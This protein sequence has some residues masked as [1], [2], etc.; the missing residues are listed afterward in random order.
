MSDIG[1]KL[2]DIVHAILGPDGELVKQHG[3]KFNEN[4]LSYA[5]AMAAHFQK[6][7]SDTDGK[8]TLGALQAGTGTGKTIGYLVPMLAYVA[9]TGKKG[10]VSTYTRALQSQVLKD[11]SLLL[12]LV[13]ELTGHFAVVRKRLGKQN[14]LSWSGINR[15]EDALEEGAP[16]SIDARRTL[17]RMQSWLS[18]RNEQGELVNS[19]IIAD[20]AEAEDDGQITP[21]I[22]MKLIELR[23]S[24]DPADHEL[25]SRDVSLA[26]DADIVVV[27]H[28]T[29]LVDAISWGCVLNTDLQEHDILVVDE[30]DQ[31]CSAAEMICNSDI[32]LFQAGRVVKAAEMTLGIKGTHESLKSLS[33]EA[34][35]LYSGAPIIAL[36]ANGKTAEA[37]KRLHTSAAAVSDLAER[38]RK[39]SK[40]KGLTDTEKE[41][42]AEVGEVSVLMS[43]A[44]RTIGAVD[45]ALA[46]SW[47][48]IKAYPSIRIGDS[49]PGRVMGKYWA[50]LAGEDGEKSTLLKSIVFTSATLGPPGKRLPEAFDEFLN[51]IGVYRINKSSKIHYSVCEELMAMYEPSQFGKM[52]FVLCDPSVPLPS[53]KED[54]VVT[55]S[56]EWLTY[57]QTMIRKAHETGGRVLVLTVS[58]SDSALLKEG[59]ADLADHIIVHERGARLADC[60]KQLVASGRGILITPAGWEGLNLPGVLSHVVITRM[61]FMRPDSTSL[62][63]MRLKLTRSLSERVI[64]AKVARRMLTAVKRRLTQGMGRLIRSELDQGCVWIA[65]PRFPL[66]EAAVRSLHPVIF[67]AARR[68]AIATMVESIPTRFKYGAYDEAKVLSLE[69]ELVEF[70]E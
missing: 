16:G 57:T 70:G 67:R 28:A 42:F 23:S 62:M 33:E 37:V 20:F 48:P 18:E 7:Q 26:K 3:F 40:R 46:M 45:A 55:R 51:S 8:A 69:G 58:Y 19:G 27:N 31:L 64:E 32:S 11:A 13:Q 4:Q 66:P 34:A 35:N 5:L 1:K 59:L 39:A 53:L 6:A 25:Y 65:D 24:D 68:H 22:D 60:A 9:L 38:A 43:E 12:P 10:I 29:L 44:S 21:A 41:I 49:E 54:D 17:Q 15:M 14:Y 63:L 50:G 52:E 47:S 2:D 61:P 56:P 36:S 30:A